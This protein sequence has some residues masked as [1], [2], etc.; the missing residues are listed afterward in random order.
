MASEH[1][2]IEFENAV[3][4]IPNVPSNTYEN[5]GDFQ[6]PLPEIPSSSVPNNSVAIEPKTF[7]EDKNTIFPRLVLTKTSINN[8]LSG[9]RLEKYHK[10]IL[11]SVAIFISIFIII[12]LSVTIYINKS[13]NLRKC[14]M[15]GNPVK[16]PTFLGDLVGNEC[17]N[18]SMGS[19]DYDCGLNSACFKMDVS[20]SDEWKLKADQMTE[21]LSQIKNWKDHPISV[22]PYL[23]DGT[24]RGCMNGF[25]HWSGETNCHFFNSTSIGHN[26]GDGTNHS[27]HTNQTWF[28]TRICVCTTDNCN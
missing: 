5:K 28:T 17:K 3:Y 24:F 2:P 7:S 16:F 13:S 4:D 6:G 23:N 15:C 12:Y 27:T 9:I 1:R 21:Y 22:D 14:Q 19:P 18:G 25:F 8:K 26:I 10:D 20:H 11:K